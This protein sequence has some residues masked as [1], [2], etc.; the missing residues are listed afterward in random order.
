MSRE[1]AIGAGYPGHARCYV[2]V[3]SRSCPIM[4]T[5]T[6][7]RPKRK[8]VRGGSVHDERRISC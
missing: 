7:A 2:G 1:L 3:P 4:V 8:A 6:S 5:D